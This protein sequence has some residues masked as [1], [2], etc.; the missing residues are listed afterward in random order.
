MKKL[1]FILAIFFC[2]HGIAQKSIPKP[3]P[4]RL[5]VD[6][7]N[8]LDGYDRDQL[9]RKLVALDDGSSNQIVVL[10]VNTLNDEPIE[11]VATKTFREWGIG[12]KKTNNGVLVLIAVADHT[13]RIEVGYGLEG[14]IPDIIASDIIN[15]DLRPAFRQ[16]NY[17]GGINKAVD[18]LSKA[19]VGDYKVQRA[20]NDY[21]QTSG[22]GSLFKFI[23]IIIFVIIIM[24]VRGR[25]GGTGGGGGLLT[26]MLL[27]SMLGGGGRGGG[28]GDGG[29]FG[30]GGFGGF[31]GGSSGGGGASGGW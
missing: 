7:A 14:A 13:V 17:Y 18:D 2:I 28:F 9:E 22:S 4:P 10:T 8:V 6:N 24:A 15:N 3:N 31:G 19:A 5:V 11:D 27:G 23:F 16:N 25:G 21:R 26:G 20:R 30:G 29:G 12:N 1:F